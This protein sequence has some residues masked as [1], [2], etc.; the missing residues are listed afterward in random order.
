MREFLLGFFAA[1]VGGFVGK[2][3][4]YTRNRLSIEFIYIVHVCIF[5]PAGHNGK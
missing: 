3:F 1:F 5:N 4:F 2:R